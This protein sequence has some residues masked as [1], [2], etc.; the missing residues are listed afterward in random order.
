MTYYKK[1]SKYKAVGIC[2]YQDKF[3]EE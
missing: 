1:Q 3:L 2:K